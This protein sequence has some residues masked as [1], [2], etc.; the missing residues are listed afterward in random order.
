MR[1]YS[2]QVVERRVTKAV[3]RLLKNDGVLLDRDVN[4]RSVSHKLAE[5]L[6]RGFRS[7]HVDCE[8]N[9]DRGMV[10]RLR[11]RNEQEPVCST[12]ARTVYPDIVVHKRGT[13]DNL[14]VVEIKKVENSSP[15]SDGRDRDKLNAFVGQPFRY[16]YGLFLKISIS[17]EYSLEWFLLCN[18][19]L[20]S[21][22]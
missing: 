9:R 5:Y 10:K 15:P 17:G 14:L 20:F 4:E 22:H 6:Q 19:E 1:N 16:R 8:Y 7:W 13:D 3:E 21:E 12:R 18:P 11:W 2:R